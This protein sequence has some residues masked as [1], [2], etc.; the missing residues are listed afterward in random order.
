[1]E[2]GML[3]KREFTEKMYCDAELLCITSILDNEI[4]ELEWLRYLRSK[5]SD[6]R[7]LTDVLKVKLNHLRADMEDVEPLDIMERS[8]SNVKEI[9]DMLQANFSALKQQLVANYDK[10]CVS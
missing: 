3:S 6:L 8:C 2:E 10:S 7:N 9:L 1:M 4:V 5:V